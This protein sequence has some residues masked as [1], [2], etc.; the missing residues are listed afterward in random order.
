[1]SKKQVSGHGVHVSVR[2]GYRHH[3]PKDQRPRGRH[4]ELGQ[5]VEIEMAWFEVQYQ[6]LWPM[7][8]SRCGYW[9]RAPSLQL[10]NL[11]N[12]GRDTK[13]ARKCT[14]EYESTLSSHEKGWWEDSGTCLT[15]V[16]F[17]KSERKT[18]ALTHMAPRRRQSGNYWVVQASNPPNPLVFVFVV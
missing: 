1:M 8:G 16:R 10:R 18:K 9:K 5:D 7:L 14:R 6:L 13:A 17:C 15:F 11:H 2:P 3:G 12:C 4:Q